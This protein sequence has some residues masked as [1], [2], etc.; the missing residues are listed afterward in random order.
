MLALKWPLSGQNASMTRFLFPVET[1][2]TWSVL[3]YSPDHLP[4]TSVSPQAASQE[5]AGP[6]HKLLDLVVSWKTSRS[7]SECEAHRWLLCSLHVHCT[8]K[9]RSEQLTNFSQN[10]GNL[11]G[12]GKEGLSKHKAVCLDMQAL[13]QHTRFPYVL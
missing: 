4:D 12:K 5:E 6:G 11:E 7:H 2:N 3:W 1:E 9:S 10:Q 8:L 13:V